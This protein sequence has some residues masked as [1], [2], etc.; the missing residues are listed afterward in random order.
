MKAIARLILPLFLLLC[1][2]SQLPA[3]AQALPDV[4]KASKFIDSRHD[5]ILALWRKLALINAPSGHED[6]RAAAI[7]ED[8]KGSGYS[9]AFRD[10][11]GNVL[12]AP[13]PPNSGAVVFGAH[14]DTVVQPGVQVALSE[15][16]NEHGLTWTGPASGDDVSGV[17]ALLATA[18]AF[19]LA[20]QFASD[21]RG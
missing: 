13:I 15:G 5:S 10:A 12:S 2:L 14:V 4:E 1:P 7:L 20:S 21:G 18:R 19:H 9:Q 3:S 11:A 16:H 17:V 8:L 6:E